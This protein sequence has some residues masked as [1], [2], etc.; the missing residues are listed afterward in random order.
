MKKLAAAAMIVIAVVLLLRAKMLE[1][2][3][4]TEAVSDFVYEECEGSASCRDRLVMLRPCVAEGYR[5]SLLPG[6]DEI[7]MD[8]LVSCL[9]GRYPLPSLNGIRDKETPFPSRRSGS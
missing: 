5:M 4:L 9:N 2:D 8:A 6:G 3:R 7:D 1:R